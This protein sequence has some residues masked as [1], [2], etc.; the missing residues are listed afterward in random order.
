MS[1]GYG[2]RKLQAVRIMNGQGATGA[3]SAHEMV[4]DRVGIYIQTPSTATVDIE[5]SPDGAT[6]FKTSIVGKT[7]N[8]YFALEECHKFL[9]ANVVAWTAG[10]VSVDLVQQV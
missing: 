5:T 8:G 4:G 1:A 6:W 10:A 7:A 2:A 9:R 3:G